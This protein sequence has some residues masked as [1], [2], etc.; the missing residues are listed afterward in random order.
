MKDTDL[1]IPQIQ[2]YQGISS[3]VIKRNAHPD[4]LQ[5]PKTCSPSAP[6][7][8]KVLDRKMYYW[9]GSNNSMESP[10]IVSRKQQNNAFN[11]LRENICYTGLNRLRTN[12]AKYQCLTTQR[13]ISCLPQISHE[14]SNPP[15]QLPTIQRLTNPG[16]LHLVSPSSQ[17]MAC[18]TNKEGEERTRVMLGILA[19]S[20]QKWHVTSVHNPLARTS[21]IAPPP[22]CKR[23]Y[24]VCVVGEETNIQRALPPATFKNKSKVKTFS[25]KP[26]LLESITNRF[27]L[28]EL[29]K[30]D[31]IKE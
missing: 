30:K 7:L 20:A 21:H 27:S 22:N 25:D 4:G 18:R 5:N 19:A 10:I 3:R 31:V 14:S 6:K 26:K 12:E 9:Q 1:Q 24:R 8:W 16:F 15:R 13:F 17:H 28:K 2:Q 23:G 11:V 29:P